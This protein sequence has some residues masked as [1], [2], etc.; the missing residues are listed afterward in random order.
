MAD[1]TPSANAQE[2]HPWAGLSTNELLSMV[3]YELYGPVSALGSEV[4]RLSRGEFDDDELLT[5]I[6]QMRDATN[7]L[8]RLVVTL[9]R[10]TADLPPE[11]A[12]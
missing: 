1:V 4:D 8:S 5:L 10:Y 7:Q 3:V 11:P 6:D 2:P 9:K 12:P